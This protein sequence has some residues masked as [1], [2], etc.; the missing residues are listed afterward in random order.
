MHR[1]SQVPILLLPLLLGACSPRPQAELR[2]TPMPRPDE[3][4]RPAVG[5]VASL[6]AAWTAP[7]P[8]PLGV[9]AAAVTSGEAGWTQA[10]PPPDPGTAVRRACLFPGGGHFY[11]G[12][13]ARA[14]LLLGAAAASVL[15]GLLLSDGE[16]AGECVYNPNTHSCRDSR[17]RL[18]L[19]IG[20]GAA[21]AAWTYGIIDAKAS[22]GRV[23]ARRAGSGG[24]GLETRSLLRME[25][26]R[27]A[28]AFELRVVW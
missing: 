28:G 21:A 16:P 2:P 15:A 18:P 22:V 5:P 10:P 14:A 12:E 17:G 19:I 13:S 23:N 24:P 1:Q 8:D 6:R 3:I 11:T 9:P 26:D 4:A 25:R 7:A 20:G 27:P